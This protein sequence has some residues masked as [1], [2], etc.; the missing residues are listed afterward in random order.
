MFRSEHGRDLR[1]DFG[2]LCRGG[3]CRDL[4]RGRDTRHDGLVD[5]GVSGASCVLLLADRVLCTVHVSEEP[6]PVVLVVTLIGSRHG[7]APFSKGVHSWSRGRPVGQM[8]KASMQGVCGV[9][10]CGEGGAG[11]NIISR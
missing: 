8:A 1:H 11:P 7:A 2:L 10:L 9:F 6:P 4:P 5:H 3:V